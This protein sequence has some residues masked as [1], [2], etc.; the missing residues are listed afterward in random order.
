MCKGTWQPDPEAEAQTTHNFAST[1]LSEP[2]GR[3]KAK[4]KKSLQ[5]GTPK[6]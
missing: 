6:Q 4:P 3:T 5:P 2:R 1:T